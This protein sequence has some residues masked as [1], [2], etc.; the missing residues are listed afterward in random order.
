ML[1]EISDKSEKGTLEVFLPTL[2]YLTTA[3]L[4]IFPCL[5]L[6]KSGED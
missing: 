6:D 2:E 1:W 3:R 5:S 4:I